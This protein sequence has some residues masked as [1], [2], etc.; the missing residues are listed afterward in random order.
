MKVLI[1]IFIIM[2]FVSCGTKSDLKIKGE[3]KINTKVVSKEDLKKLNGHLKGLRVVR[4]DVYEKP[5]FVIKNGKEF[6]SIFESGLIYPGFYLDAWTDRMK[7]GKSV[8][9][10]LKSLDEIKKLL[11]K[12]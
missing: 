11:S 5:I 6:F 2:I 1:K 9:Y 3:A 10:K 8:C 4:K 7:G 12:Y